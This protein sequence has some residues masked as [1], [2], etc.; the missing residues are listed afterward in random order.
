MSDAL[1][2]RATLHAA[3]PA[4]YN[5]T[6]TP[7]HPPRCPQDWVVALHVRFAEVEGD[8]SGHVKGWWG[9]PNRNRTLQGVQGLVEHGLPGRE[10][11]DWRAAV[12]V[13]ECAD[14]ILRTE[15]RWTGDSRSVVGMRK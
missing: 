8:L 4:A 5:L 10:P 12:G 11:C 14:G 9:G 15:G 6:Q 7:Q 3:A 13:N 1:Q 2:L